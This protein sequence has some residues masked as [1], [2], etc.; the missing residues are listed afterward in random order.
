MKVQA[1]KPNQVSF[2]DDGTY[3]PPI[4]DGANAMVTLKNKGYMIS[5]TT[6]YDAFERL[7]K[8]IVTDLENLANSPKGVWAHKWA[9]GV[10]YNDRSVKYIVAQFGMRR[11]EFA[12]TLTEFWELNKTNPFHDMKNSISNYLVNYKGLKKPSFFQNAL[13]SIGLH[14]FVKNDYI[15]LS[16]VIGNVTTLFLK[17]KQHRLK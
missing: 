9:E 3:V 17:T 12:K 11:D 4:Y 6:N 16:N 5:G 1:I 10:K 2:R 8:D 15:R 14:N 13:N 7:H